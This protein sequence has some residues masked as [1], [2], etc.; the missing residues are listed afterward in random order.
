M[1][2]G[3]RLVTGRIALHP[4]GFGFV[5]GEGEATGL[6]AFVAPPAL[7]PFLEGDRV[8]CQVEE[9]SPGRYG[10]SDLALV[11][12]RRSE[13]FGAVIV[14]GK[15]RFLKVDRLV[16]N[17]DWRLDEQGVPAPLLGA[18]EGT[19]MVA[20]VRGDGVVPTRIVPPLDG[21]LERV[22]A[23]HGLR[24]LFPEACEIEARAAVARGFA[25]NRRDLRNVPTVTIDAPVSKDLDDA[26]S[27]VP[28]GADGALRL[29]VSI[30][31]VDALVPVGSA[32]DEEARRRG[33]SAYLAGRVL[34]MLPPSLSEDA[35]SLLPGKDRPT[36][37][38]E[39]RI[40]PEGHVTAVDLYESVLR[41][42]ARLSYD[43]VATFMAGGAGAED[44]VP[45]EVVPTLRWLRTAAARID[46]VRRAR[47]GVELLREEAYITLDEATREPTRVEARSSTPAHE[48][49]ERLMV[50]TNEAVAQWLEQRGLPAV[51][52]VH[53]PPEPERARAL[54]MLA[55]NFGFEA[56]LPAEL[57]PRSLAALEAQCRGTE[58]APAFLTVL[59]RVL[60]PARYTVRPGS[61]FGL[62]ATR[63]LHFTS[64]IRRYADLAVHRLVKAHLRGDREHQALDPAVESLCEHL[65]E[66]AYRA[67][68]AEAER[69]RMLAAR[70]FA[71][72][73]GDELRG[74]VISVKPFGL[75]V[76]LAGTGV[77]GTVAEG[78]LTGGPFH[79]DAAAYAFEG[80]TARYVVGQPLTVRVAG[81]DE[82]LGRIDL[83]PVP[84]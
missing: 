66:A 64:P 42:T 8:T 29:L 33:T 58:L 40:D 5:E 48:L 18:P 20:T 19:L 63:Y 56:G 1:V 45:A 14:H 36:L 53:P 31:D 71:G 28:A 51:Y 46:V 24:S 10:A 60:G 15:K 70:H 34:P 61:H 3:K 74:N 26:L 68:K 67:T 50:A 38:A 81:A 9:T 69:L 35:L 73:V 47:G 44:Q 30:A 11:E 84:S 72:R 25:G 77:T 83:M 4:R 57:T 22:V 6:T 12:R 62:A 79:V 54:S 13:V 76:Q 2:V 43:Q 17:T 7:N 16:S 21:S 75:V 52:R 55:Q 23:R 39:L 32:L 65:N 49:V 80:S 41:S 37:T 82:E 78:S 59:S 27:V